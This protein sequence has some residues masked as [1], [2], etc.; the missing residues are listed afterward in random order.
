MKKT[1]F[2]PGFGS[3]GPNLGPPN[4]FGEFY[5]YYM[6]DIVARYYCMQFKGTLINQTGENGKKLYN[7]G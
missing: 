4:F 3:F 5:L 2:R 7:H 1:N 6:S